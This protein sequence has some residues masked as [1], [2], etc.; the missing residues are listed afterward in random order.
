MT[1]F[2]SEEF[3]VVLEQTVMMIPAIKLYQQQ[4]Q[5][6]IIKGLAVGVSHNLGFRGL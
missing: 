1:V 4:P 5:S 2:F 3:G 6:Q